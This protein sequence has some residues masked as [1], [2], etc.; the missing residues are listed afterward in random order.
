MNSRK[1]WQV[2]RSK[3]GRDD[4]LAMAI[5]EFAARGYDGATTAGIARR[6]AVTQPLVHHHFGSKLGLY[7]AAIDKVFGAF[8]ADFA[9]AQLACEG[10]SSRERLQHLLLA[11]LTFNLREPSFS[12]LRHGAAGE[13]YDLLYERWLTRL[14]AIFK[15]E[16]ARAIKEGAVRKDIDQRCLFLL[17]VGA[18]DAPFRNAELS[19]RSFGLEMR[20]KKALQQYAAVLMTSLFDGIAAPLGKRGM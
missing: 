17:L 14:V 16:I 20:K 9:A 19:R 11:L 2:E 15:G 4:I 3:P 1:L 18:L 12:G 10:R 5:E 7:E 13:A 6:A 8:E